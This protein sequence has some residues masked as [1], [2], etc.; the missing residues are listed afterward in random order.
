M[1]DIHWILDKSLSIGFIFTFL[2][3]SPS[4][5]LAALNKAV[6]AYELET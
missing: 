3:L 1:A 4:I 6:I 5:D 2:T